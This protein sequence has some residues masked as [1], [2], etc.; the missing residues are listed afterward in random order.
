[1]Q[2]EWDEAVWVNGFDGVGDGPRT[3]AHIHCRRLTEIGVTCDVVEQTFGLGGVIS[4]YLR[5]IEKQLPDGRPDWT[6]KPTNRRWYP[7]FDDAYAAANKWAERKLSR[8]VRPWI[9][10][11][12]CFGKRVGRKHEVVNTVWQ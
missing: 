9:K 3:V 10:R 11:R 7:T 4:T 8:R 5:R 1:M 12:N 2:I 6:W